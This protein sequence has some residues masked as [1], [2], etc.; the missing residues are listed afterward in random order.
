MITYHIMSYHLLVDLKWQNRLTLLEQTSL[1]YKSRAITGRTAWCRCEYATSRV[2]A[3]FTAFLYRPLSATVQMLKLHSDTVRWFSRPW[4][5]NHGNS[6]QESRAIAGC[7]ARCGCKFRYVSTFSVALRGFHCSSS[8]FEVNNS[9]NHGKIR[10]FNIIYLLRLNSLFNS[11]CLPP[12]KMLK[13]YIVPT[14][15]CNL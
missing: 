15:P 2:H 8:A 6:R 12:F 10:V 13:L 11:H 9:I 4:Q 3:V 7:T 1:S 5:F 14:T